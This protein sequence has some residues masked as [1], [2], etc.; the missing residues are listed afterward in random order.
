MTLTLTWQSLRAVPYDAT[1]FIHLTGTDGNI[2]AQV[3]R[4]PLNGRFPTSSWIPGQMITDSITL[5]R[6][7]E[8]QNRPLILRLGMYTW[9]SMRRLPVVNAS[10]SAQR[11]DAIVIDV[12]R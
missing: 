3:D 10:G 7:P 5:P 9:P 4:Q 11:D 6:P 1:M 2:V 12:P 8:A